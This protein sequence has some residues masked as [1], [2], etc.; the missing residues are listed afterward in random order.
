MTT[1]KNSLFFKDNR[2]S[3]VN[4]SSTV[5]LNFGDY[6]GK[7]NLWKNKS[8]KNTQYSKAFKSLSFYDEAEKDV[9]KYGNKNFNNSPLSL[10]ISAYENS[11]EA[12]G[13]NTVAADKNEELKKNAQN[14]ALIKKWQNSNHIF[15]D[16]I[17]QNPFEFPRQQKEEEENIK[18]PEI[19]QFKASQ[20]LL[21]PN[22]SLE[23]VFSSSSQKENQ[24]DKYATPISTISDE[25]ALKH[26][27]KTKNAITA[28][29]IKK[30]SRK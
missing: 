15:V 18:D 19:M 13:D 1:K 5:A 12:N 2:K 11:I 10:H 16:S 24:S 28:S 8:T 27:L 6:E 9:E 29:I 26:V 4:H 14:F 23:S 20:Q 3:F 25:A 7:K 22:E 30:M 21:N 17:I